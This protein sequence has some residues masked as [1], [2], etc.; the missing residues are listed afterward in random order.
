MTL[1]R[2]EFSIFLTNLSL[3]TLMRPS[4]FEAYHD[5]ATDENPA[6]R[7]GKVVHWTFP[8][9]S[10]TS[11]PGPRKRAR[12][13]QPGANPQAGGYVEALRR[14]AAAAGGDA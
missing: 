3:Q 12:R 6:T 14:K 9:S 2:I 7:R 8:T 11:K 10:S 5:F 13:V 1:I 4:N